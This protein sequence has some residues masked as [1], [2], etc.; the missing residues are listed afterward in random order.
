MGLSPASQAL[1][2]EVL[3]EHGRGTQG[4][5]PLPSTTEW[6]HLLLGRSTGRGNGKVGT[7]ASHPAKKSQELQHLTMPSQFG[8][9]PSQSCPRI[10]AA[11][12]WQGGK[13]HFPLSESLI[14]TKRYTSLDL[15]RGNCPFSVITKK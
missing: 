2:H 10:N 6:H 9:L 15:R 4:H 7:K 13:P 1:A 8:F 14:H 3:A 11:G 12:T 5:I